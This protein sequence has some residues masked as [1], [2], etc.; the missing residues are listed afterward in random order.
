MLCIFIDQ[1]DNNRL[2]KKLDDVTLLNTYI[3]FLNNL[4]NLHTNAIYF[5]FY[6]ITI[7]LKL[8]GWF[9][10]WV[11]LIIYCLYKLML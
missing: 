1:Y 10:E 9:L 5:H 2:P 8:S 7:K 6:Y 3:I 11:L 4:Y